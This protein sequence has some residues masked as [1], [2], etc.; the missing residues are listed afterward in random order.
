MRDFCEKDYLAAG[1]A[2]I[3]KIPEFEAIGEALREKPFQQIVVPVIGGTWARWFPVVKVMSELTE[4]PVKLENA[5]DFCLHP[6]KGLGE[7]TLVFTASNAGNTKE[8]VAAAKLSLERGA[9]VVSVGDY[10]T[11]ELE[12][13][14]SYYVGVPM[15]YGEY[16]YLVFFLTALSVLA[17]RGEFA[18]YPLWLEQMKKLPAALIKAKEKFD[19]QA[20]V[21][22][23]KLVKAPYM[24]LVSSGL[25][26]KISYWYALCVLEE[27]QWLHANS[28]SSADFVHGTLELME[29][30]LPVL[31]VKGVDEYRALDER[32]E[33][34]VEK[35]SD[36]LLVLD[37]ADYPLEGLDPRFA[38]MYAL[39]VAASLL[40]ERLEVY[41]ER[42]S[43]PSLHFRRYYRKVEY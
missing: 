26:E 19:P 35:T 3:D 43:G 22:A 24:V 16:M 36:S 41:H 9:T 31:L 37:T 12:Q 14:S 38:P 23:K 17:K 32:V 34:F 11:C 2:I 42:N 15:R 1:A 28:V 29:D 13:H 10:E 8:I 4:L 30:G 7:H 39:F 40:S 25:L 6:T 27:C 21:I 33:K 20:A 18:D 5:A